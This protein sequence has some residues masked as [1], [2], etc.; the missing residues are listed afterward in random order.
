LENIQKVLNMYPMKLLVPLFFLAFLTQSYGQL[1][2]DSPDRFQEIVFQESEIEIF[3]EVYASF[4]N[5]D[6]WNDGDTSL[7][8]VCFD[9]RDFMHPSEPGKWEISYKIYRPKNEFD[10]CN[11]R[12]VIIFIHGGG[13]NYAK[14]TN[15][16][17]GPVSQSLDLAMRG[18]VV[19][20]IN[21]RK[22]WDMR[23]AKNV[24]GLGP[25]VQGCQNCA[26]ENSNN[27]CRAESF[28]KMNYSMLQDTRA[29]H[30]KVVNDYED[31]GIDPSNVFYLGVST[32][33]VG[34]LHA[35]YAV[36]DL[37]FEKTKANES[38]E[39]IMG[40]PD[41]FGESPNPGSVF[42]VAGV[43]SIAG[44]ISRT[45]WIEAEDDIPLFMIHT[46]KDEAVPYCLDNILSMKYL[47]L[48]NPNYYLQQHGPGRIYKHIRCI[49]NNN[50]KTKMKLISLQGLYHS[51]TAP[52]GSTNPTDNCDMYDEP[53][54]ISREPALFFSDIINELDISD[55]HTLV[56]NADKDGPCE[57]TDTLNF[58]Q[59]TVF[60]PCD[61]SV[62]TVE[63]LISGISIYPNPVKAGNYLYIQSDHLS[64]DKSIR[65]YNNLGEKI[66]HTICTNSRIQ[67]PNNL[68]N[69]TYYIVLQNQNDEII[70]PISIHP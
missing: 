33:A 36:D 32:G 35:A 47:E 48:G 51:F 62:N 12:P 7:N 61:L 5:D 30:R 45:E 67:I 66:L 53:A 15:E 37:P 4:N 39:S 26:C 69:G 31:L 52:L 1:D 21:Y 17:S 19:C 49:E 8:I 11:N 16:G 50:S 57:M 58:T 23:A 54:E 43:A 38:L 55:S 10:A 24:T 60:N 56:F 64:P 2:C 40:G 29:A 42:H 18:Y 44:S 13:Y 22:G 3:D 9:P 41:E 25:L 6:L 20:S 28:M 65:I 46:T 68:S 59:C 14:S 70:F 27:D 34:A 63:E